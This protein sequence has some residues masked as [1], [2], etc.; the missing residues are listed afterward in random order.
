MD[1]TALAE[2]LTGVRKWRSKICDKNS[3]DGVHISFRT[4]I[5]KNG[6]FTEKRNVLQK[7]FET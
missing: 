3:R 5:L 6:F 4:T 1:E 7:P 2:P